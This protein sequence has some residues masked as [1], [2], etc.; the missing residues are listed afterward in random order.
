[1]IRKELL[2]QLVDNRLSTFHMKTALLFTIKRFPENIW[3]HDNLVQCVVLCLNTLRRF[4]KRRYCPHYTIAS[5]NLFDNKLEVFEMDW[6]GTTIS[7][8]IKSK[9]GC[10]F[11]LQI[12][13]FGQRFLDK[14]RGI[15]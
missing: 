10:V 3:R 1:M 9:V 5:V 8:M 6:L 13:K 12:D 11:A 2:G 4:L 7:T 15:N 14:L